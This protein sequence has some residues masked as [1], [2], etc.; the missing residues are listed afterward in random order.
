MG[1]FFEMFRGIWDLLVNVV[2]NVAE[3]AVED[4]AH[5]EQL[6]YYLLVVTVVLGSGCWASSIAESRLRSPKLHFFIGVLLPVIYPVA[7]LFLMRAASPVPK[8]VSSEE[9]EGVAVEPEAVPAASGTA[10]D[11]QPAAGAAYASAES[12]PEDEAFTPEYFNRISRDDEGNFTGP[13]RFTVEG[14]EIMA[15]RILEAL[16]NVVVI[17]TIGRG[18]K[19]QRLRIPYQ[20]IESCVRA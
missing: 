12:E 19:T 9:E 3:A 18:G 4:D 1:S 15:R 6:P 16:P 2:L 5:L 14:E 13:W 7:I 11:A 17:E 20:R 10:A 8:G